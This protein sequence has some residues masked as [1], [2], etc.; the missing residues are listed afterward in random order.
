MWV[1]VKLWTLVIEATL[2]NNHPVIG[3]VNPSLFIFLG[4]VVQSPIKQ[5]KTLF[6]T[7][8]INASIN[9]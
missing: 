6:F 9:F 1:T 8:K 4:R 3:C 5:R 2:H 7:R